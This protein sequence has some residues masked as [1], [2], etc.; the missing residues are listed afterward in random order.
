MLP[1]IQ[2]IEQDARR[3]LRV[4]VDHVYFRDYKWQPHL[5][6]K[7]GIESVRK[8]P[9]RIVAVDLHLSYN[10]QEV[11]PLQSSPRPYELTEPGE[12]IE[13]P[14]RKDLYPTLAE[15]LK[16]KTRNE[17]FFQIRG[18]VIVESPAYS[19]FM[20]FPVDLTYTMR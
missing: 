9:L 18:F 16:N 10:A 3:G 8:L 12:G 5:E 14:L 11:G 17:D 4:T 1:S 2:E 20:E 7:I 6:V 15:E 19:G 13:I